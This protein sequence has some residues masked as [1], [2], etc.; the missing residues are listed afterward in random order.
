M[1]SPRQPDDR[2]EAL[3]IADFYPRLGAY[4]ARQHASGYDAVAGRARFMLWLASH[5]DD[6]DGA[7]T[8]Y[9]ARAVRTSRLTAEEETGLATRIAAGRRAEERLDEGGDALDGE[10]RA[11][12]RRIAQDGRQAGDRLLEASLGLVES[13]AERFTGRGLPLPDLVHEGNLGLIRAIQRYDHTRH[14]RFAT[15]ATWWIRQAITRAVAGQARLVPSPDPGAGASDDL[16]LTGHR[17]LQ[18]LG[19]EPTPEE[20]AAELDLPPS[21]T[22]WSPRTPGQ[23]R[24]Q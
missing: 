19:R 10:A 14:Y 13:V 3:F 21:A 15:Y 16:A 11:R 5:A 4:L 2:R 12:L 7:L 6:G 24:D 9:A 18:A 17:M 23:D 20:L 1:T 22:S 8:D